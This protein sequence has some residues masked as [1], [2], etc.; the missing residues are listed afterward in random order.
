VW[1][2]RTRP[3]S[4]APP[5]PCHAPSTTCRRGHGVHHDMKGRLTPASGCTLDSSRHHPC[6]ELAGYCSS[7]SSR[8]WLAATLCFMYFR[9]MF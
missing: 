8:L 2:R 4:H 6:P 1:V 9:L 7:P 5:R 3:P